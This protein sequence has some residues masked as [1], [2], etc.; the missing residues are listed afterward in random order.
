MAVCLLLGILSAVSV[1]IIEPA[2]GGVYDGDWLTL[3][4]I[5]ENENALPD[6]VVFSLNGEPFAAGSTARH[7]LVTPTWQ[8]NART[9]FSESPRRTDKR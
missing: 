2:D 3:R 5:V 6:S 9:G 4:A 1:S 8:N 7:R